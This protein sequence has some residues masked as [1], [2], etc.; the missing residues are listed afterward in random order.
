MIYDERYKKITYPMISNFDAIKIYGVAYELNVSYNLSDMDYADQLFDDM[1]NCIKRDMYYYPTINGDV[2][3]F[4]GCILSRYRVEDDFIKII[5]QIDKY[6]Q[7]NI[8]NSPML[9]VFRQEK[10]NQLLSD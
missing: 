9:S 4:M 1:L 7:C 3:S 6:Y 10:L 2:Y 5:F 8:K